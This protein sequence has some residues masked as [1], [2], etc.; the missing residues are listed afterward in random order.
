M[1]YVNHESARGLVGR[2]L[3]SEGTR[4]RGVYMMLV[5]EYKG[6]FLV[7]EGN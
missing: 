3:G 1:C 5:E 2:F 6:K 4:I 7:K